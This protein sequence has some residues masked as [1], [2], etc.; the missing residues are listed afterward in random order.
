MK[1]TYLNHSGFLLEWEHSYWLFDYYQGDIPELDPKKDLFVFC[2]HSHQDHFN[3]AVFAL[4]RKYPSARYLFA[5]Q[6]KR[7]CRKLTRLPAGLSISAKQYREVCHSAAESDRMEVPVPSIQFLL[8]RT[9]TEILDSRQNPLRVHTLAST[10]C[11][12]A[13]VLEYMGKTIFHAGDLHWW[14]WPEEG[15]SWN[16]KMT[17]DYK[18]E[19]EYLKGKTL[20]LAFYPLDPR[21]E[22]DY[23]RGMDYF[24]HTARVKHV[25]P[26]HFWNDFSVIEKY[27]QEYP[28]PE[29]TRLYR[30]TADGQ[31]FTLD[32][33]RK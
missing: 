32:E 33:Q 15:D 7:A 27:L 2:S 19:M 23:G 10:D 11:G 30:L 29:G 31:S 3:P 4:A 9:D 1:V 26:M 20:D 6:L 5:N 8:S 17:A 21:Q 28:L 12:C 16:Q 22:K 24:L 25:F 18:K 13:F 14:L